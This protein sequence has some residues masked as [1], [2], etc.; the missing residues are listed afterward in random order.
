[1]KVLKR[2]LGQVLLLSTIFGGASWADVLVNSA[3]NNPSFELGGGS[4]PSGWSCSGNVG[5]NSPGIIQYIPGSDGISGLVPDGNQAAILSTSAGA[6][7]L[8]QTT[9]SI[10]ITSGTTYDLF[11]WIGVPKGETA[12]PTRASVSWLRGPVTDGLCGNGVATFGAIGGSTSKLGPNDSG[13]VFNI[14]LPQAGMWQ[15]YELTYLAQ[16]TFSEKLGVQFYFDGSSNSQPINIDLS[17]PA[18]VPEASSFVL[19]ASSTGL[20]ALV[21]FLRRRRAAHGA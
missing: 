8:L 9:S 20:F 13:C 12:L 7:S 10:A 2:R 6:A 4:C 15:E 17:A 5:Y 1:M 14:T 19:V 3:L 11:F 21:H 16:N 18:P